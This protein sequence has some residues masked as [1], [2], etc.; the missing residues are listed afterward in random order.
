MELAVIGSVAVAGHGITHP[1]ALYA[2][3]HTGRVNP[4][5]DRR[6]RRQ[7]VAEAMPRGIADI[8]HLDLA[9][10]ADCQFMG[11]DSGLLDWVVEL[12]NYVIDAGSVRR[13][14]GH[15]S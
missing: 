10:F 6:A 11:H 7:H 14:A 8:G 13:V 4:F 5:F 3:I 9:I 15:D 12:R 1:A 2:P